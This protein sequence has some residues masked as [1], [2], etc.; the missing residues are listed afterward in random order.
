MAM[1]GRRRY[2]LLAGFV[3]LALLLGGCVRGRSPAP[4]SS[5]TPT[6][7][8][9]PATTSA[10][11]PTPAPVP[12]SIEFS[13]L[14]PTKVSILVQAEELILNYKEES[15][16]RGE[17][18]PQ[19]SQDREGFEANLISR[20]SESLS[21]Y[22]ER[23]ERAENCRVELDPE[24]KSTVLKCEVHNA[25][26]KSDGRYQAT[27]FWLLGRFRLDFLEDKFEEPEKGLSW[28]GTIKGIPTSI[29]LYFPVSVPAWGRPNGHCH[30]HVWWVEQSQ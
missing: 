14:Q 9:P 3:A 30:A 12:K 4:T 1:R 25:V 13:E 7:T 2:A 23:K 10:P 19:I 6:M 29:D 24:R 27:F 17:D 11:S 16:W 22:G 15:L 28:E 18:F 21:K 8:P 5:P 20:F 26:W